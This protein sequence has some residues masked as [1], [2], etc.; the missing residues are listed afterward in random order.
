[1]FRQALSKSF[2]LAACGLFLTFALLASCT[3]EAAKET[4]SLDFDLSD[5]LKQYSKV[6]VTILDAKD[7]NK[8]LD[9]AFSGK[10]L[11]PKKMAKYQLPDSIGAN[12]QIRVQGIDSLGL[13]ALQSDIKVQAGISS[14][15][16]KTPSE[17]LPGFQPKSTLSR[18]KSL[19]LSTGVLVPAFTPGVFVYSVTVPFAVDVITLNAV[20]AD[21]QASLDLNGI[22]MESGVTTGSGK[23]NF[24][25]NPLRVN[26]YTKGTVAP[27]E[28]YATVE[29]AE[30]AVIEHR[31]EGRTRGLHE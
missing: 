4:R 12:F 26:V 28:K 7:S 27:I 16:Q 29:L 13:L 30:E 22:P 18:L 21:T 19:A 1:M 17:R 31:R 20:V 5:S 3:T 24:G 6:V 14:A 23:L 11:D 25:T 15:A 10:L 8:I 9:T 2:A